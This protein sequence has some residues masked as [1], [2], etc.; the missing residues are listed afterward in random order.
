MFE[1]KRG[2]RVFVAATGLAGLAFLGAACGGQASD[3]G[4]GKDQKSGSRTTATGGD[5]A[6]HDQQLKLARCM[7]EHGV[8]MPDPKPGQD[9]HAISI[10]GNGA[11]PKKLKAAMKACRQEAGM[12]ASQKLTQKEKDKM[13]AFARCM[14]E[15]GVDMPDPKFGGDGRTRARKVPQSGPERKKFDRANKTCGSKS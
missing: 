3:D 4:T 10:D 13:L 2:L 7:R 8:D 11:S 15:H 12:P 9:S 14:R 5:T 1:S 6:S